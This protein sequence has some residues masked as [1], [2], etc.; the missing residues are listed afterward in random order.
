MRAAIAWSVVVLY[1]LLLLTLGAV[2]PADAAPARLGFAA[3][4]ILLMTALLVPEFRRGGAQ[5]ALSSLLVLAAGVAVAWLVTAGTAGSGERQTLAHYAGFAALASAV[6][7]QRRRDPGAYA[8]AFAGAVVVAALDELVQCLVPGRQGLIGDLAIPV[9]GAAVGV[10]S[11][12]VAAG[13]PSHDVSPSTL[14]AVL[15]SLSA[16]VI[17]ATGLLDVGHLGFRIE[18]PEVYTFRSRYTAAELAELAASWRPRPPAADSWSRL[19]QGADG[20]AGEARWH[21]ARRDRLLASGDGVGARIEEMILA[22]H[23]L[24]YLR[25]VGEVVP[26]PPGVRRVSGGGPDVGPAHIIALDPLTLWL[27]AIALASGLGLVGEILG[28]RRR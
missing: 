16:C 4:A 28:Y 11:R 7:L 20:F 21:L 1:G 13:V 14:R 18:G 22:H 5:R 3:I 6:L 19:L 8:I 10:S 26:E 24:P 2:V 25:A 27:S 15:W 23:Y 12:M 17:A 9:I